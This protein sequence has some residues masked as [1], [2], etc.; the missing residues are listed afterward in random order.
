MLTGFPDFQQVGVRHFEKLIQALFKGL[1]VLK[2][3][4]EFLLLGKRHLYETSSQ[5]RQGDRNG[6]PKPGIRRLY[7]DNSDTRMH[8][9]RDK[10][11][12]YDEKTEE[13]FLKHEHTEPQSIQSRTC[14]LLSLTVKIAPTC[15]SCIAATAALRLS[16]SPG[17][18]NNASTTETGILRSTLGSCFSVT[19]TSTNSPSREIRTVSFRF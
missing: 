8:G 5:L 16:S 3:L 14:V 17:P 1:T 2:K 11:Q 18:S 7:L 13:D 12:K 15:L 9:V 4:S 10:Q 6:Y 19:L